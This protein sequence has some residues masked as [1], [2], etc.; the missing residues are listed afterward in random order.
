MTTLT[1]SPSSKPAT[2]TSA[3]NRRYREKHRRIDYAPSAD[4]LAIITTWRARKL[5]NCTAG[6]LDK[7][8]IAGHQALLAQQPVSGDSGR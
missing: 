4:V 1:T 6:V 8:L 7:L 3:R 2:G 5:D